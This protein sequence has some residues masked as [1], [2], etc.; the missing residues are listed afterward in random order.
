MT[1]KIDTSIHQN[2]AKLIF[3]GKKLSQDVNTFDW[4]ISW[5]GITIYTNESIWEIY[6]KE[7]ADAN[8][9][10]E[11]DNDDVTLSLRSSESTIQP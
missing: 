7:I 10:D 8:R 9:D 4:K 1:G 11:D 5:N 2:G 3:D 6:V